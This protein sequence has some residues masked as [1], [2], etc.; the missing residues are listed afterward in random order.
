MSMTLVDPTATLYR[1]NS[2]GVNILGIQK[3]AS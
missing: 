1:S 2:K 3:F